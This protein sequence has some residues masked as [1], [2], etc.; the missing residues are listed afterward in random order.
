MCAKSAARRWYWLR[1]ATPLETFATA[2]KR[3]A[4]R[5]GAGIDKVCGLGGAPEVSPADGIGIR[6]EVTLARGASVLETGVGRKSGLTEAS[7]LTPL[8]R[9][10]RLAHTPCPSTI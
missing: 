3:L 7:G 2:L 5:I 1:L 10:S 6:Q 8:N 4:L 9:W